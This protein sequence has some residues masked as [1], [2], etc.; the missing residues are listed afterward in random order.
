MNNLSHS[1]SSKISYVTLEINI[2]LIKNNIDNAT[3]TPYVR[4][5]FTPTPQSIM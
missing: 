2:L 5:I 4:V 1:T 3:S